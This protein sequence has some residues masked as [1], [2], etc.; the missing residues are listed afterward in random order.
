MKTFVW[1]MSENVLHMFSTRSFMVPCLMFKSLSHFYF[2]FVHDVKVCCSF[3][4]LYA[5]VQF[6]QHYLLKGLFL[7]ILPSFLLCQR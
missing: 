4:D 3:I 5:A 6:S 2:I 1:L 7:P